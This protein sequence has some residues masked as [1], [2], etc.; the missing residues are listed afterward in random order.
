MNQIYDTEISA[1]KQAKS[2]HALHKDFNRIVLGFYQE[3][4]KGYTPG[5]LRKIRELRAAKKAAKEG[6][7]ATSKDV[8]EPVKEVASKHE[9]DEKAQ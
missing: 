4:P 6:L 1:F 2:T 5:R 8:T 9:H 7:A 3:E